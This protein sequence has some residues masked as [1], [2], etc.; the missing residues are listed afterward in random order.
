[1]AKN[2]FPYHLD[3]HTTD[4]RQHPELY[5]IGVGEQGVLLVEPYKSE[6]LPHW[7]FK[8][9]ETASAS[10]QKIYCLFEGY[11]AQQDF[12]GADMARKFLQMGF[13]RARRYA[14]HQSGRKY[15]VGPED[16]NAGLAYPYSSGS[17]HKGN[18][19]L[20]QADDALTNEKARAAAV[21]KDFWFRAKDHP[22]YLSQ[23]KS[24]RDRY[25]EK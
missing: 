1:M 11:L 6:I 8:N 13:T 7:R 21:F 4:F 9:V 15:Q 12:V 14:N 3:F 5:R 20:P 16:T 19:V 17:A 2:A 23:K 10:A 22:D 18:D 24:F 25:Y